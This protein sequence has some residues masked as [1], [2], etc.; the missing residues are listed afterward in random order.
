MGSTATSVRPSRRYSVVG[1]LILIAIGL[2]FLLRNFGF[3][4][5]LF[6]NF[7]KFWPVL[8]I[9]VGLVRV[10]EFFAS[11]KARR[12]MPRMGG[13][14]VF[15]LLIVIVVGMGLSAVYRS[16]ALGW[17][18]LR[19]NEDADEGVM[20]LFGSDYTYDGELS[21][22][23]PAGDAVHVSCE[24]GNVTVNK[25]DQPQ[26]KVVY[27]KRV[28]AESQREA[29]SINKSTTP[30]FQA[31]GATVEVQ[32][33]TEGAGERGVVSD[34]EVYLPLK[35]NLEVTARHGDVEVIQRTGDV[36][37]VS[38]RGD[39]SLDQVTGNANI[40]TKQGSLEANNV[41]GNLTAD[42]RL[43]D[44]TLDSISGT[45]AVTAEIF[46]EAHLS[47][48]KKGATIRTSR[49]ELQFARLNGDLTMDSSDLQGDGLLGPLSISTKSK[50]VSLR[51]L[52]GDVHI[53]DDH[54]N[55][56]LESTSATA[57]GN[58]DLTTHHGD[59]QLSLPPK[60]NFQYQV[61]T[62]HGDISS[63]F[64]NMR[65]ESHTGS[66][67][68]TGAVG[69]GGVKINVTSDNGDID[70]SKTDALALPPGAR[71]A[72]EPRTQPAKPSHGNRVGDVEVM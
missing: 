8:L 26:V 58:L 63:D 72:P 67:S 49:T 27:H 20:H 53:N 16:N 52:S 37:V 57:L 12:P 33:N 18:P 56:D 25:W 28:V 41:S 59:V 62:H 66:A 60:A 64:E 5:A 11:R 43:D 3:T 6:R 71:P 36:K 30:K 4:I 68:A 7:V 48:L 61:V 1:P 55:I 21:Q 29:D 23:F 51:N 46:G 22:P 24:R 15:L 35:A 50:D 32:A 40:T 17:G 70:I 13:V 65:S 14:T 9:L 19:D 45:V 54:G 38:Q 47:E 69:R 34:I 2:L 42:G 31:Q 10:A 44:L 39:V